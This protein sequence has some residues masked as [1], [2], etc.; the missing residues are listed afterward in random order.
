MGYLLQRCALPNDLLK[1][2]RRAN[3]VL[4][5]ALGPGFVVEHLER[6]LYVVR[7]R[8]EGAVARLDARAR[9]QFY[10]VSLSTRTL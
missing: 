8:I 3:L 5:I 1:M 10:V 6:K 2:V 9:A 7:K 4:E